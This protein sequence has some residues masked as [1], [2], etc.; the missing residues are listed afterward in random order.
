MLFYLCR[1]FGHKPAMRN[2]RFDYDRQRVVTECKRCGVEMV[3]RIRGDW[4]N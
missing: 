1:L 2:L 3:R 4:E